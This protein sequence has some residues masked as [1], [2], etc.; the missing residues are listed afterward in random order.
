[1][2]STKA[3]GK[4]PTGSGYSVSGPFRTECPIGIPREFIDESIEIEPSAFIIKLLETE[5]HITTGELYK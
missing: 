2:T 5:N 1:M 4:A 3:S